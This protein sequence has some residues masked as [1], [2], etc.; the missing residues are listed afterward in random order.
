MVQHID[1]IHPEF[2]LFGFGN[3]HTL[4]QVRV[5]PQQR[6][7]FE[8]ASAKIADLPR[9]R[10]HKNGP[11]LRIGNRFVAERSAESVLRGYI[12]P[13]WIRDLLE[14]GEV[15]HAIRELRDV[16]HSGKIAKNDRGAIGSRLPNRR[17]RS[18]NGQR[19]TG[20]P[21]EDRAKLP[22]LG[23]MLHESGRVAEKF[24]IR[25]E[26]QFERSVAD[27]IVSAMVTQQR[28]IQSS[29]TGIAGIVKAVTIIYT[30]GPAPGVG[31]LVREA[32]REAFRQLQFQRVICGV[33]R[34]RLQRH[35][36]EL[37]IEHK[38]ILGQSTIS[39]ETAAFAGDIRAAVQK[40]RQGADIAVRDERSCRRAVPPIQ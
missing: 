3:P 35:D 21:A 7:S 10:I 11:A 29:V 27:E 16:S 6:R 14:A 12:G 1:R 18:N 34:I 25:A 9:R 36:L 20:R 4:D 30:Q 22:T 31:C 33:V 26:W 24:P 2:K 8:R 40:I 28:F 17:N 13:G 19:R 32:V 15:G 23:Q 37:W 5:E 38:E 39:D